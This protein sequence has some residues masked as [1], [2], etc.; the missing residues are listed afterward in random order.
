MSDDDA[1]H[2]RAPS[3]E[4]D[5][6]RRGLSRRGLFRGL[7]AA[8]LPA[9]GAVP[10]LASADGRA[11]ERAESGTLT[12]EHLAVNVQNDGT[13]EIA[14]AEGEQLT[15]PS[16]GTSGLTIRVDGTNYVIG[17]AS[18]E[19]M[20]QYRRETTVDEATGVALSVW[21]LPEGV[22]VT[23][24]ISLAGEA[25]TFTVSVDNQDSA[26]HDVSIRFLFD[27][28]VG[29]QD[30]APIFVNGQVLTTE[31][32]F[33]PPRFGSWQTYDQLPNPS[34][35]GRGTLADVPD[36]I[37][38]VA[39][40]DAS[41]TG[42]E[43]GGFDP[44]KDFFTEGS[45][46]SP[47]SDSAGL[48]YF[49]LGS[50]PGGET[51]SVTTHYGVGEPLQSE[52]EQLDAALV[53]YR[54]AVVE[55]LDR[56]VTA[57]ARA[58]ARQ[59]LRPEIDEAYDLG[60][61]DDRSR[62]FRSVL[63]TFFEYRGG[64]TNESA[65]Y[66]PQFD[67]LRTLLD[68]LPDDVDDETSASLFRAARDA[69]DAVPDGDPDEVSEAAVETIRQ[70]LLGT[71]EN[72]S[73]PP[74]V[75]GETL[76]SL[77][78]SFVESFDEQRATFVAACRNDDVSP[79]AVD[80]MIERLN[81]AA[82]RVR[83]RGEAVD[84]RYGS[85]VE[86][87]DEGQRIVAGADAA[88]VD[89]GVGTA[90]G[91]AVGIEAGSVAADPEDGAPVVLGVGTEVDGAVGTTVGGAVEPTPT[92]DAGGRRW[93]HA[94]DGDEAWKAVAAYEI[95]WLYAL[96]A[97]PR[98]VLPAALVG[99]AGDPYADRIDTV[100]GAMF[101]AGCPATVRRLDAAVSA[102][103]V[104]TDNVT[105]DSRIGDSELASGTGEV[106]VENPGDNAEP[107]VP[108]FRREDCLV[109]PHTTAAESE[110]G[111]VSL[112]PRSELP[113]IPPGESA[114]IPFSY[115]TP[116]R[117]NADYELQLRLAAS[118]ASRPVE[119]GI[120]FVTHEVGTASE[121][122]SET[123]AS[124]TV[125]EGESREGDV[126]TDEDSTQSETSVTYGGSDLDLHLY[127][128]AGN[129][130][131]VDYQ[132]GE[133][134]M[135]I[136]GAESTG[137]D[138]GSGFERIRVEDPTATY[139]GEV[140]AVQ[141]PDVGSGFSMTTVQS[142]QLSPSPATSATDLSLSAPPGE[143]AEGSLTVRET[144]GDTPIQDLSVDLSTLSDGNGNEADI[145][146]SVAAETTV[147]AGGSATV[148]LVIEVPGG[149]SGGRYVGD[150]TVDAAD[151]ALTVP[152][153][154]AV[155]TSSGLLPDWAPYALGAGAVGAGALGY[156]Y[157]SGRRGGSEQP[158]AG[159][160]PPG[161][162]GGAPPAEGPGDGPD[163]TDA[164]PTNAAAG[165]PG[166]QAAEERRQQGSDRQQPP[167]GQ[168]QQP[169]RDRGQQ[170]PEGQDRQHPP[171]DRN[172]QPPQDQGQQPPTDRHRRGGGGAG[173][174]GGGGAG[175]D[176]GQDIVDCP[177][178]GDPNLAGSGVCGN[179]GA[180]LRRE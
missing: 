109:V 154:V 163:A 137:P 27:Y 168:G 9:V 106:V 115:V 133:Y 176:A 165:A 116:Y 108:T 134:E 6:E 3:A 86:Q 43:Y 141:T 23:Q 1:S 30:G 123:V 136:P 79:V 11:T 178:C 103:Q 159:G 16:A 101:D 73:N 111:Y 160:R 45:T 99:A 107:I 125:D 122:D 175:G 132:S 180:S 17:T 58:W 96:G 142:P 49:E 52:V 55:S 18:G 146:A 31:T 118:P 35:T 150:L 124:G 44:E 33:E 128:A 139:A 7:A 61:S 19:S 47:E 151:V 161:G 67:G 94:F 166:G 38:F 72:Q 53:D 34:L 22:V 113:E 46:T 147:P 71:A 21:E 78:E 24:R 87:A 74:T 54:E 70:H 60:G 65:T 157:L 57:H 100:P 140:V 50:V 144:A 131:G 28:Q 5:G 135:G 88:T 120:G 127:D 143:G 155:R 104:R 39:W 138:G 20:D 81:R 85:I 93:G 110:S 162:P 173:A 148:D 4:R 91:E 59:Y 37:E 112:P 114:T 10:A 119:T 153:E 36:K 66:S 56:T 130:V 158:P 169:Q 80:G 63:T 42:Y 126:E 179:C 171:Q 84:E 105:E 26:A 152:V 2:R 64:R 32:R 129:H 90:M 25:A 145:E 117:S 29:P 97:A 172:Q 75:G 95:Q 15:Y 149:T 41:G 164:T 170:P 89:D 40:E 77:R 156:R 69:F 68:T 12:N 14:T 102:G 62:A 8:S 83:A 121:V 92:D 98:R 76:A 51:R 177:N 174:A 13:Y 167:Q 48:L 82:D